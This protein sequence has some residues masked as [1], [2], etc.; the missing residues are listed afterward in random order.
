M[1]HAARTVNALQEWMNSRLEFNRLDGITTAN[2]F[3]HNLLSN[4]ITITTEIKTPQ[5]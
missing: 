2:S 5:G 4:G 1:L 3:L